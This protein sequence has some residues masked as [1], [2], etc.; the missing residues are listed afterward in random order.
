MPRLSV[1][2][3]SGYRRRESGQENTVGHG[4]SGVEEMPGPTQERRQ[5]PRGPGSVDLTVCF[6]WALRIGML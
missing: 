2:E 4:R 6:P 3:R 5:A 1:A